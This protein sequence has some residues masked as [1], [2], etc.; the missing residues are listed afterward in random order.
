MNKITVSLIL[1]ALIGLIFGG[2]V[3]ISQRSRSLEKL[4][5]EKGTTQEYIPEKGALSLTI[6]SPENN[7]T[8]TASS[9]AVSG[10]TAPL[11]DVIVNDS[12]L[13]ADGNG[14]FTQTVMLDEGENRIFVTAY[15]DGEV[16]ETELVVV[17]EVTE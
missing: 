9:V 12:E 13:K 7:A 11:A 3:F 2:Y 16:S 8:V 17:R 15:I 14:V 10:K 6:T 5:M 1:L 4:P